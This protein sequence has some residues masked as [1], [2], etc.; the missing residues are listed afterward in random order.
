M[1]LGEITELVLDVVQDDSFEDSI[2]SYANG[3]LDFI[4]QRYDLDSLNSS[5]ILTLSSLDNKVALP[6]NYMKG[7]YWAESDKNLIGIPSYYHDFKRFLRRNPGRQELGSL[8]DVCVVGKDLHYAKRCD[9]DIEIHFFEKPT[10]LSGT[11]DEP[12][13]IPNHLHEPLFVNYIAWKLYDL[14]EDG[15]EDPKTNTQHYQKLFFSFLPDL[16]L[17]ETQ[18]DEPEFVQDEWSP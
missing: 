3:C 16:E 15:I 13:C 2:P 8:C 7:L 17:F 1:T 5:D 10:Y 18:T 11:M 9:T 6:S 4:T 12:V 14:I